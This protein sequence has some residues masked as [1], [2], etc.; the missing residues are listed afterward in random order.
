MSEEFNKL[1]LIEQYIRGELVGEALANFEAQLQNDPALREEVE[2]FRDIMSGTELA[3]KEELDDEIKA[4]H[5]DLKAA[6]FFDK[7]EEQ[8]S[9]TKEQKVTGTTDGKVIGMRSWWAAAA[10]IALLLVAGYFILNPGGDPNAEEVLAEIYHPESKA[11]DGIIDDLVSSGMAA[12][13]DPHADS[14]AAALKMYKKEE[15]EDAHS[16]LTA[17]VQRDPDDHVAKLYLG[18][19]FMQQNNYPEAAKYFQEVSAVEGFRHKPVADWYLALSYI[20]FNS[21]D[22]WERAKKQLDLIA[23]D[24]ESDYRED[25]RN[26]LKLL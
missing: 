12:P 15:F 5:Q 25:A 21:E 6:G 18:L 8:K 17:L 20:G 13:D 26:A 7:I 11:I 23:N 9:E 19:S 14:L 2:L 3:G 24:P 10:T 1:D 4:T 16:Y 22:G